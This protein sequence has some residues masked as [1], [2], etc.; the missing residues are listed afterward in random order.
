MGP[1]FIYLGIIDEDTTPHTLPISLALLHAIIWKF[2]IIELFKKSQN[3][4]YIYIN[5][6]KPM[7]TRHNCNQQ[8]PETRS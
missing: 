8:A 4:Y 3:E 1:A 7:D 5:W 2:I 6:P